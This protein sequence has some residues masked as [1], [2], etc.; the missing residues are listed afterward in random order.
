MEPPKEVTSPKAEVR[1]LR[2]AGKGGRSVSGGPVEGLS[3]YP[4]VNEKANESAF[5]RAE[6]PQT[7]AG[8]TRT[9]TVFPQSRRLA[10]RAVRR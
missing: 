8:D 9:H 10:S 6:G 4:F 7:V 1:S 2:T 5:D 3:R